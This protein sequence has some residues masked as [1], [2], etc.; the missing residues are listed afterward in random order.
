MLGRVIAIP[1]SL[2][3]DTSDAAFTITVVPPPPVPTLTLQAPN[4]GETWEVG[5]QE[6]ITW[7]SAN[8]AGN[9]KL[10]YSTNG[11]ADATVITDSVANT[12]TYT[13]TVPDAPSDNVLVRV[14]STLTATIS[15]TSDVT[16]TIAS[17]PLIPTLTLQSPNGGEVWEVGTQ[18]QIEWSS[19]NLNGKVRLDYSTSG[20]A[21]STVITASSVNDGVY[22][23]IVPND[24]STN[25]LV[26]V[27]STLSDTISDTSDATFTI[28]GPHTFTDSFKTVS[29]R[30]LEGG[31]RI[32]YTIL[33]YDSVSA[34]LTFTD[35]IP[36]PLSY[37][38]DTASI[39]PAGKGTVQFPTGAYLSW[40]GVVT[41]TAPVTITFQADVP[42]TTTT[43]W[44]T[45]RALVS[46]NGAAP[47]ELTATSVLNG[48]NVYLPV[49]L[50]DY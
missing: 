3:S 40:S 8:L 41:G 34:T 6:Q 12:G 43:M 45:N 14:S 35:A 2:I 32:T 7:S 17:L 11:F 22:D 38:T 23:W 46:R 33:L 47:L 10:E 29:R 24:L 44:I 18:Q 20:S 26:R 31:E 50:K 1:D 16:F 21:P 15:D 13:W 39:K 9:V 48:F 4:G 30:D 27:S 42:V 28:A 37:V 49:V 19:V 36:V 5:E 25:V